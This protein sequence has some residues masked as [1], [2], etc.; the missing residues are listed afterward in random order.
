MKNENIKSEQIP[1]LKSE[2]KDEVLIKSREEERL[3]SL[4]LTIK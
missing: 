2:I 3:K 1:V 4:D